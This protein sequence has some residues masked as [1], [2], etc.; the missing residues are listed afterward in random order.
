MATP[1]TGSFMHLHL[2]IDAAGL[3]ANIDAHQLIVNSWDDLEVS[4]G[5]LR[6]WSS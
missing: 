3:P 2:G 5:G 4:Q 1:R 6:V